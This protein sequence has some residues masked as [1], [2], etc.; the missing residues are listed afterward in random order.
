MSTPPPEPAFQLSSEW[1]R[2]PR[3]CEYT[4][5]PQST[6]YEIIDNPKNEIISFSLKIRK[7]QKRG[8]RYIWRPSLDAYLNRQ[9]IAEGVSPEAIAAP[10]CR[11]DHVQSASNQPRRFPTFDFRRK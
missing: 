7:G 3:A 6:L 9:A 8:I 10:T 4:Q 1:F 11:R 2:I 5:L